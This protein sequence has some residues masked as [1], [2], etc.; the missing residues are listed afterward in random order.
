[1]S[2][3]LDWGP[4]RPPAV[5]GAGSLLLF[6]GLVQLA[7]IGVAFGL[8]RVALLG[9]EPERIVTIAILTFLG[10]HL[11]VG[12]GVL[13]MWRWWRGI[14]ILVSVLGIGLQGANLAGPPD[15]PVVVGIALG[16]AAVYFIVLVLLARSRAAFA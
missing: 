3:D 12:V 8:D 13:R 15:E 1:M 16:L 7:A 6:L 10:F 5:T 11:L 2:D 9:S 14:G 4:T